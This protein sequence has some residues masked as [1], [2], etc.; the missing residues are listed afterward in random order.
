[1]TYTIDFSIA[2]SKQI[3]KAL[4]QQLERIRLMRNITQDQLAKMAG[5]SLRTIG[6]LEKGEGISFDTLIRVM[7]ALGIQ[8]NLKV[9]LPDPSVRPVDRVKMKGSERERAR[10]RQAH[11]KVEDWSWGDEDSEESG[12]S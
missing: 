7:I 4:C 8:H 2:T 12:K 11:N 6:R 3:E 10:P 1:M 5:V 9:L